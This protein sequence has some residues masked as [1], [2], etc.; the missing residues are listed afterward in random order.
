MAAISDGTKEML[1]N[2]R[3]V[4]ESASCEVEKVEGVC[5]TVSDP[6]RNLQNAYEA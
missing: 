2:Q 1:D 6:G 5:P 3:G 4:T